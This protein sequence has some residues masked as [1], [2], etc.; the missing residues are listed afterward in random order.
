MLQPSRIPVLCVDDE[1][2]VL[3]G[4]AL[5]LHRHYAVSTATGGA[6]GLEILQKNKAIAVVLS[7]MRMP[8]MDGAAFLRQARQVSPE[9]VRLLLTGQA[10]MTSAIAAVNEGQ[11]F[12]FLTKPCPPQI[13]LGALEAAT[14]QHRLITAERV[15]IEQTLQGSIKMLTDV[16]S[17]ASPSVFGR[18]TRIKGHVHDLAEAAGLHPIWPIEMAAM[19]SQIG[20]IT[21]S[22]ATVEKLERGQPLSAD[23]Q[24]AVDRLPA[25]A[26]SLLG[27]IPRLDDVRAC[28]VHQTKRFESGGSRGSASFGEGA[29]VGARV[30]K[31][32][33]DFDAL[34]VQ[35]NGAGTALDIMR[36]RSGWYDPSLLSTFAGLRGSGATQQEIREI[37]LR[38]VTA[39]MTFADDVRT[40]TGA[41]LLPRGY[42]V[43]EGLRERIR[44]FAVKGNVR[45]ILASPSKDSQ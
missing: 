18:A 34:E 20:G 29:P 41:L 42:E 27:N 2:N 22:A 37:P 40:P 43:T 4:L 36:G 21:L 9:S 24:L 23:E 12:R 1:P 8:G 33:I 39:G 28:L 10:D 32:A 16:M 6:A 44:N 38:Q 31:I 17:L 35:G 3:E 7:D 25:I 5:T 11:I 19:L 26:D 45:V 15:L 30:L 13:L 14:Q